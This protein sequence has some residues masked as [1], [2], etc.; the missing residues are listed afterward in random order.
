M[1][2]IT[3]PEAL[4]ALAVRKHNAAVIK[5]VKGAT[6]EHLSTTE[7]LTKADAAL[8]KAHGRTIVEAVKSAL[9][10]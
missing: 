1:P 8:L 4:A 6:N 9:P 10:E 3:D 2:K 7:G 5:A